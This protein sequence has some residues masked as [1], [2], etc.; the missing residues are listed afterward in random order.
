MKQTIVGKLYAI[1]LFVVGVQL[2]LT[3][4]AAPPRVFSDG[5]RPADRRLQPLKDLDGYFPFQAPAS[6]EEWAK[7]TERVRRQVLVA[8]GLWPMPTKTPLHAKIHGRIQRDT[9]T[10]E[11]VYFESFPGFY[12]TGSLYRPIGKGKRYP[13]I[14]S[15]HGHWRDGRFYD[16]GLNQVNQDFVRGAERFMESG[17]SP[18]QARCIQLARMGCVVFHYDMIGYADSQ[19]ISYDVAHRFAKQRPEMNSE[20][21]WGLFSP[22]A[23]GRLQSVMGLQTW[24]SIRATDFLESLPDVDSS[25][26]AVTGASG[27]GTQSMILAAVEPRISV[28]V[29]AVMVSTSMQGGCTCEN[30]CLM[31]VGTGNVEFAAL[32]APKPQMVTAAND[33]TKEMATKGFPELSQ[34]YAL[35]GAKDQVKLHSRIEYGHNYNYVSRAAMYS[36]LNRHFKLGHPEPIIE[37]EIVRSTTDEMT[38]WND[39]HPQPEG[40]PDFERQLLQSW[41][42][43]TQAQLTKL[44][45]RDAESFKKYQAVVGAG[46]DSILGRSLPNEAD[47]EYDQTEKFDR[48]DYIEILGVLRN[49]PQGEALP[50][51]FYHPKQWEGEVAIWIAE[52][53]KAGLYDQNGRL[54]PE[55]RQLFENGVSVVSVDLFGQGEFQAD[56]KPI[57]KTRRVENPREAAAYTFGFNHTVF[58][59]RVHDILTVIAFTRSHEYTPK[60]IHLVGFGKAGA[61]VAAA[62]AQARDAVDKAAVDTA[63]F[64]F[65][66]VQDNHSTQF[67]PGGI[68]YDDVVGMLAVAAPAA[69]WVSG[70]T[71]QSLAVA[72][73][74]YRSLQAAGS[75]KIAA[76]AD[77]GEDEQK[78][79]RQAAVLWLLGG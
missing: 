66:Q 16:A 79:T 53:G 70:E 62:R 63:G 48:G 40:G 27:G 73:A 77:R 20:T 64:R 55:V 72:M 56:G 28:S 9:Y 23:E 54:F 57:T 11:K 7:R 8:N 41:H 19:Q 32:F 25:R 37:T 75:L 14:L 4:S 3:A 22:Q 1:T 34:L 42:K 78:A 65:A 6:K 43:D 59:R 21:A 49:K 51:V 45:P 61:L 24:N 26:L 44:Q 74:A 47:L 13:G 12:V 58:A 60:A 38:V 33:W 52:Q 30:C 15:P 17:R 31:R 68:K 2:T 76:T 10:I 71:D 36:W 50:L 67:L 5:Q 29:P 35:L 39:A 46:I 18:L 69:T